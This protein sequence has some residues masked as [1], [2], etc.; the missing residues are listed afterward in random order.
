M[1]GHKTPDLGPVRFIAVYDSHVFTAWRRK[2]APAK[3]G[4]IRV[5]LENKVNKQGLWEAGFVAI[6]GWVS[7]DSLG[8]M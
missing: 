1:A 8:K 7:P 5:I 4:S 2:T 3:Q 6:T